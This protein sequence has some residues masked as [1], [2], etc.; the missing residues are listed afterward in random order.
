MYI[1]YIL[2]SSF[3]IHT[4]HMQYTYKVACVCVLYIY[5][6]TCTS[7]VLE[8]Y[9]RR[10]SLWSA[11]SVEQTSP[12]NQADLLF[13]YR[14][15][16]LCVYDLQHKSSKYSDVIAKT[17]KKNANMDSWWCQTTQKVPSENQTWQW[18]NRK[19]LVNRWFSLQNLYLKK[20]I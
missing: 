14:C 11:Q 4:V 20:L 7:M 5:G 1:L 17:K 6:R 18:K 13:W 10:N 9:F 2:Y 15:H 16:Q 3:I 19:F 8:T 12:Q